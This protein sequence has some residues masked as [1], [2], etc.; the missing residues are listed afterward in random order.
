MSSGWRMSGK[1]ALRAEGTRFARKARASRGRHALR[2]E[3][4]RFARKAP[5][6]ARKAPRFARK[7]P[8]FA[9]RSGLRLASKIRGQKSPFGDFKTGWGKWR[10][11]ATKTAPSGR[12]GE[13]KQEGGGGS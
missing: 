12:G 4:T 11:H 6:F 5:R 8:R 13:E 9:R 2:A 7:A 10:C 1:H 3:G